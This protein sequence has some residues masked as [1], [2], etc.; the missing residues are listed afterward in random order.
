MNRIIKFRCWFAG[1][2][3]IGIPSIMFNSSGVRLVNLNHDNEDFYATPD[4]WTGEDDYVLMQFTGLKDKNGKEIYEG[5]ILG[6]LNDSCFV[7][8]RED[9]ASFALRK[10]G[11]MYDHYFGEGVDVGNVTVIGNQFETPDLLNS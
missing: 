6:T 10:S 9:L 8:W 11:W 1:K 2:M 7:T 4:T 5:D 3:Y